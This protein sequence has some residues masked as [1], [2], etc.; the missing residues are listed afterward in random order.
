[1]GILIILQAKEVKVMANFMYLF[2]LYV[3]TGILRGSGTR[4]KRYF[5]FQYTSTFLK[6]LL[7]YCATLMLI[8]ANTKNT[9]IHDSKGNVFS[10]KD[11]PLP[12][13]LKVYM[14]T[15]ESYLFGTGKNGSANP[16]FKFKWDE[17]K[18]IKAANQF[19]D[20]TDDMK[21]FKLVYEAVQVMSPDR[22]ERFYKNLDIVT[23]KVTKGMVFENRDLSEY[24][25]VLD[26]EGNVFL[27]EGDVVDAE[28]SF[29]SGVTIPT[30]MG[31][32]LRQV[33]RPTDEEMYVWF[34]KML[35]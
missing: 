20:D 3:Y 25:T 13:L 35:Y 29:I 26:D 31:N 19:I 4:T 32:W 23:E 7:D 15:G 6:D 14:D 5:V 12:V 11:Y 9:T 1:M 17:S 22:M 21:G 8:R 27:I 18:F 34:T 28:T 24:Y 10:I 16:L 30:V 33:S 2:I